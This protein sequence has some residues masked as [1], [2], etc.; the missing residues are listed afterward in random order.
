MN[1]GETIERARAV[2]RRQHK[3]LSTERQYLHWL[4]LYVQA[5]LAMPRELT[6]EAKLERFLSDLATVRNVSAGTQNQAFNAVAWFYKDVLEKPLGNVDSLRAQRPERVRHAPTVQETRALIAAV[7]DVGG[8]PVNLVVRLL[9][10]CGMRVTEPLNL[11]VKDLDFDGQRIF[12]RVAKG[13]K[14]R[15]VAMPCSLVEELRGQ[16]DYAR[17]VWQRDQQARVP[18]ELPHM[19]GSKYPECRFAWPWAWVFPSRQPCRHPRTGEI[20]RWRMHEA[21]VQNAIK[22]ARRELGIMVLPHEL[23]HAYATHNLSRGT[24]IK[25]LSKAM[26]HVNIETTAGYC[27]AEATSVRS[28][29]DFSPTF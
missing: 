23:R 29:L 26:G 18:V 17:A 6:S 14:D 24:N 28:P 16:L 3:A 12:I 11:R 15:V 2:L 25:A 22:R 8:Y 13:A 20:V 21:N 1:T 7:R 27:H 19:L 9:Y 4:R 10:G 5:L